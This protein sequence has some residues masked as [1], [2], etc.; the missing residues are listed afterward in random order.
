MRAQGEAV[1]Q[2]RM[3]G[4]NQAVGLLNACIAG[5]NLFL[6]LSNDNSIH[7]ISFFIFSLSAITSTYR[8]ELRARFFGKRKN[9]EKRSQY[10]HRAAFRSR[11]ADLRSDWRRT[12]QCWAPLLD[13][14]V[15]RIVGIPT[16]VIS[17]AMTFAYFSLPN[18]P[19]SMILA[20]VMIGVCGFLM[21]F[22]WDVISGKRQR[23]ND[24]GR[25]Q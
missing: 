19:A 14:K 4:I 15:A 5:M 24:E 23:K 3:K 20:A 12:M 1:A 22:Y 2:Q 6:Y 7:L 16:I 25:A 10:D 18:P 21:T 9:E 11:M 13:K 17:S 8:D